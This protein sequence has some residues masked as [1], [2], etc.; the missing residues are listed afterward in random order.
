MEQEATTAVLN[1]LRRAQGQLA[2]V[3]AMMEAG[4]DCKDVVTQLAAV[5]RALRPF[6]LFPPL[7]PSGPAQGPGTPAHGSRP[8]MTRETHPRQPD[9][10]AETGS[11][12]DPRFTWANERTFLAWQRTALALMAGGVGIDTFV[13]RSLAR[14]VTALGLIALGIGWALAALLRWSA[15]GRALRTHKPLPSFR[16]APVLT[17][18][19]MLAGCGLVLVVALP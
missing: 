16:A 14:D 13:T 17:G 4:R 1:R 6:C 11:D 12:P 15:V 3:I 9:F 18:A 19:L 2:G 8:P 10:P 5:S 7:V